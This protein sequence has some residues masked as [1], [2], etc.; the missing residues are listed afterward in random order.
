M[1]NKVGGGKLLNLVKTSGISGMQEAIQE[2]FQTYLTNQIAAGSYDPERDP[3]F[4]TLESA[5]IGGIVGL[6]VPTIGNITVPRNIQEK[7]DK[8]VVELEIDKDIEEVTSS[9]PSV[10]AEIDAQTQDALSVIPDVQETETFTETRTPVESEQAP[11][12]DNSDA[13][14]RVESDKT[15]GEQITEMSE[16]APEPTVEPEETTSE[17]IGDKILYEDS[18]KLFSISDEDLDGIVSDFKDS[19]Q[20]LGISA[21]ESK[22]DLSDSLAGA[23]RDFAADRGVSK[24]QIP[25]FVSKLNDLKIQGLPVINNADTKRISD[26]M[27]QD[28]EPVRKVTMKEV[29]LLKK[30][31]QDFSNGYASSTK[32]FKNIIAKKAMIGEISIAICGKNRW[33]CINKGSVALFK[34]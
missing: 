31:M 2:S 13:N 30:Q 29:N 11:Q 21:A 16:T 24:K 12:P 32:D 5:K 1:L 33:I 17:T 20:L 7:L 8:K 6:I 4:Q 19:G 34:N 18:K 25:L 22:K 26:K 27:R 10:D 14:I 3:L 15:I 9:S 23:I 28:V